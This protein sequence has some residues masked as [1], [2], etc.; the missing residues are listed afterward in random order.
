MLVVSPVSSPKGRPCPV[1]LIRPVED[2]HRLVQEVQQEVRRRR[3]SLISSTKLQEDFELVVLHLPITRRSKDS[4]NPISTTEDVRE[5]RGQT[6][7]GFGQV[8]SSLLDRLKIRPG[9]ANEGITHPGSRT[10]EVDDSPRGK[11]G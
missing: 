4:A 6:S 10:N 2:T 3:G 11:G 9:Q 7:R 1:L 8:E 5:L